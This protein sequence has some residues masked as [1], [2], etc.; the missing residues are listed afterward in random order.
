MIKHLESIIKIKR[1]KLCAFWCAFDP[2]G[3]IHSSLLLYTASTFTEI[4]YRD[5]SIPD[6]CLLHF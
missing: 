6:S 1:G 5:L 4:R 2:T 3:Y